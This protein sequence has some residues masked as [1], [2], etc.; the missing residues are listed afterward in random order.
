[1]RK[2]AALRLGRLLLDG[3]A[4]A[5]CSLMAGPAGRSSDTSSGTKMKKTIL[6]L[7]CVLAGPFLAKVDAA[8]ILR[9]DPVPSSIYGLGTYGQSFITPADVAYDHIAFSWLG[10][11]SAPVASGTLFLMEW[12]WIGLPEDL[13]PERLG[14]IAQSTGIVNNAYVF[15]PSVQLDPNKQYWVYMGGPAQYAAIYH[16]PGAYG[17][18]LY[19]VLGTPAYSRNEFQSASYVLTGNAVVPEP[20]SATL[21]AL[22]G[23][24]AFLRARRRR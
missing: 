1:M 11:N 15:D 24:A 3:P 20:T 22:G 2:V 13:S 12:E 6:S 19:M 18:P 8:T 7:L 23:C 17:T 4:S 21:L 14:Y 9:S 16:G 5:P 10:D